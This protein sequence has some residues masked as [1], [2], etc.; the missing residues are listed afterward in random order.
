MADVKKV[1]GST[2][3]GA[4][5]GT[6][7]YPGIGTAL[8]A[9]G[10]FLYGMFSGGDNEAP[11]AA[12][13]QYG[14]NAVTN[15]MAAQ[16]YAEGL[17]QQQAQNARE[18]AFY[19]NANNNFDI[20]NQA[21]MRGGPQIASSLADKQRQLAALG[22][23]NTAI[24][25]VNQVG[26]QLQDLGTRPM[27]DSYAAAQLQQ[28]LAGSMAQQLSMARSGRSLGSGQA[29]MNQAAFNNAAL[30]QQ[31]NQAAASARIQ[32]QN[33]YNQF[34]AGALGAA[35]QQYGAGGAL[36]G[37]AGNQATTIRSGNEGVQAQ[38]A[39]LNLQQQGVNNQTTG[40]YNQL[41]AQQQGYGLQANTAGQNAFQFG[42]N[43]ASN[44]MGAQ[45]N[46]DTG[47]LSSATQVAL[48]NQ[49]NANQ[50]DAANVNAAATAAGGLASVISAPSSNPN[51]TAATPAANGSAAAVGSAP[52]GSSSGP[53]SNTWTSDFDGS[54]Q[55]S[56]E[57]LKKN[58][59]P[60][61][62]AN[63]TGSKSSTA[64]PGKISAPRQPNP[65]AGFAP[66]DAAA[67]RAAD[68]AA[69]LGQSTYTANGKTLDLHPHGDAP[70]DED[71]RKIGVTGE[72]GS[73]WQPPSYAET[74][75]A[76]NAGY[77]PS[78]RAST[79][80]LNHVPGAGS[81]PS[82]SQASLLTYLGRPTAG[83]RLDATLQGGINAKATA[84]DYGMHDAPPTSDFTGLNAAARQ[85]GVGKSGAS[86]IQQQ[87]VPLVG[88]KYTP[89][90]PA[91]PAAWSDVFNQP[92]LD[93]RIAAYLAGANPNPVAQAS[94]PQMPTVGG[95]PEDSVD[96]SLKYGPI[97]DPSIADWMA[98]QRQ[99]HGISSDVHS[100]TRIKQLESQLAALQG[101]PSASFTPEA[102][103]TAALDNSA[104]AT[105]V[106]PGWRNRDQLSGPSSYPHRWDADPFAAAPPP[107]VDLRPAQ[108]YSY[109]YKDPRAPGATPGR[110]VGPM[111]QDLERTAAAGAVHDTPN[112]KQVDTPRLTM[113]NTAA[114][115]E[116]QRKL[117]R[118]EALG[119]GQPAP[120]D[121]NASL[122]PSP[123]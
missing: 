31:T 104:Y 112:G 67:Y 39:A 122:Y 62:A 83:P 15:Q 63:L 32:E 81:G 26:G 105:Q 75:A 50:H 107:A 20:A 46:A 108:G 106:R 98:E 90:A 5:M 43:Q 60:V 101:P 82:A 4:A 7:V 99:Q 93:P 114:I 10:G 68:Q 76:L 117:Q 72:G 95:V 52:S 21:Q 123:R 109:E 88:A 35:G 120:A 2:A 40:L 79:D 69:A 27:G 56:D 16:Q 49:G 34:Q 47:R 14:G 92:Q 100:K 9:A 118:L 54:Q 64:T 48:A 84:N 12:P 86:G 11:P 19:S 110:Q 96:P 115:S 113:V 77:A 102:P 65:Y 116:L 28:G 37:Q 85:M 29:A 24:G 97:S 22:G 6:A 61:E 66:A 59:V 41:G 33:A 30:N 25:N 55:S 87:S 91:Q 119:G 51:A 44:M 78:Q 57:R 111:A 121:Y 94:A 103:D 1:A 45:L 80:V 38:N 71:T 36:A 73:Q 8:G 23:T 18:A 89:A 17:A 3:T 74:I 58:I 13:M 70:M 42:A 53:A